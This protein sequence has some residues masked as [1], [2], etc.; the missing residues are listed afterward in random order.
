[1]SFL[2]PHLVGRVTILREADLTLCRWA[3]WMNTIFCAVSAAL[4]LL[5]YFPPSFHH[6]NSRGSKLR[7]LAKLD[8]IGL[9]LYVGGAISLLLG[10]GWLHLL[11]LSQCLAPIAYSPI[12]V[13]STDTT[14]GGWDKPRVIAPLA[15]GGCAL[16]AFAL[17]G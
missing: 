13:W 9:V 15:V 7:E 11:V 10:F 6:L 12:I 5:C 16:I 2:L 4:F 8:Y 14:V 17:W 1:M 3:Y